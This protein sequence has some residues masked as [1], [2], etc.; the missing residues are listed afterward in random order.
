MKLIIK[1]IFLYIVTFASL[2]WVSSIDALVANAGVIKGL[3]LPFIV[4]V[5]LYYI[6]Y[7]TI[8]YRELLKISLSKKLENYLKQ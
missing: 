4:F 2:L 5:V 6:C 7:K 8:S 3:L 1:A